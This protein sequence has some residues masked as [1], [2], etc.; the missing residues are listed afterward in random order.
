VAIIQAQVYVCDVC[1][2]RWLPERE[3]LPKQCPSRKCRSAMWNGAKQRGRPKK[4]TME[5]GGGIEPRS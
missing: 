2:H 4:E 1:G 5:E 3:G